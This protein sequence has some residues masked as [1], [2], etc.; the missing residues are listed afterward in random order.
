M[1][2]SR[3][4]VDI[5][6]LSDIHLGTYGCQAKELLKYLKS[7]KPKILVLNGDIMDI[8]QF[9]KRYW[10]RPHMKVVKQLVSFA[11]EGVKTYYITGNHDEILRKFSGLSLGSFHIV[12]DLEL[13]LKTGKAWFFHGDVFDIVIQNSKWLAKLGSVGYDLLIVLNNLINYVSQLLGRPKVSMSKKIKDNVK[14]AVR[15]IHN[16]EE[17]AA[18]VGVRRGYNYVVCGHI[19]KAQMRDVELDGNRITYL[20]SGDWI[21]N[22]TAL[23]YRKGE[24]SIYDFRQDTALQQRQEEVFDREMA[25]VDLQPDVLLAKMY[26]EFQK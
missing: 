22:L 12:N 8:W 26:H 20:N 14:S 5:V 11:S 2:K 6:V 9:K 24:W 25:L 23:E 3:R 4:K 21:E 7:I 10:P 18:R 17:T 13:E 19:H 15:Y 16:F 1:K